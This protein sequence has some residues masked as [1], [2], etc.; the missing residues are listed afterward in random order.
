MA[1][2]GDCLGPYRLLR[3]IGSGGMG[4]V[5]A[6]IHERMEQEVA[7]KVLSAP[8]AEDPQLVGR[9]LQEGRALAQLQ[10]PGVVGVLHCDRLEDGTAFLAMELLSGLSL[11]E[12]MR[13]RLA[14]APLGESLAVAQQIAD[15]M[16][17]VHDRQ[18]VHRDLKPE[19]VFLCPDEAV[20]PGYRVKLLD[21]GIA[22]VP[23]ASGP[24]RGDTQVRTSAPTLIGTF[25]YM[26]P[27][28]CRNATDVDGR[29]DVYAL[30]V[31][32]FELLAGQPPFVSAEH[33]QIEVLSMHV[34]QQPP[35]L[36][37][38]APAVP[39]ALSAF[40]ASMLAKSPADR[41]TMARCRDMLGRGW[42]AEPDE[43]P[44][45]GLSPFSEAQAEL[46]FGRR[47]EVGEL[48]A[49]LERARAG[50]PRWI[51]IEGH[52]GVGKS[53]LV[54]AGILPRLKEQAHWRIA[55]VRAPDD[56][57]RALQGLLGS[58]P[59]AGSRLLLVVDQ[60]EEYLASGAAG[61]AQLD[62]QLFAALT[63]R[64]CPLS[65]L[66]TLRSDFV[67]RLEQMPLLTRG[68]DQAVRYHLRAMDEAAMAEVV[69]AM[70]RRAGLR[71]EEGL[72]ERMARDTRNE[73][74][75]LPLLGHTLRKLWS[76]RGTAP[77]THERY[78]QLGGVGGALARRRARIRRG[79][80]VVLGV[81]VVA[82]TVSAVRAYQEWRRAEALLQSV[83][84][85][86]D[87]IVDDDWEKSRIPHTLSSRRSQ[88]DQSL[89]N[90]AS[91]PESMRG[92]PQTRAKLIWTRHRLSDLAAAVDSLARADELLLETLGEIREGLERSPGDRE[93]M[94]LLALNHSKRGKVAMARGRLDEAR[95]D[96]ERSIDLL[97]RLPAGTDPVDDRRTLATSISELAELLARHDRFAEAA[98]HQDHAIA[99]FR[100][101][102]GP[103]NQCL[104]AA[105]LGTRGGVARQ[106]GDLAAAAGYLAEALS[107]AGPLTESK[108]WNQL[109]RSTLAR[110]HVEHA[111]LL[112]ARGQPAEA[113]DLYRAAEELARTVRTGEPENKAF[114][115]CLAESLLGHE[116]VA[117]ARGQQ[118]QAERLRA[119]RCALTEVF[120]RTDAEDIRFQ[121]LACR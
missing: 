32:L 94:L 46:F 72:P 60:L 44:I 120:V 9:F 69:E 4:Q 93:L 24:A 35:A 10:H 71:L 101:N 12:W 5:F 68:L 25:T 27:E 121:Q 78:E 102:P 81:A 82:I 77:L 34:H 38:A 89:K 66:T 74:S 55:C 58:Q 49:L 118:E 97:G 29:S 52:G 37:D 17:H 96:F 50:E 13:R 59:P 99:L 85:S 98:V 86:T 7:L 63:A 92:E 26:A 108:P 106:A 64:D 109:Y 110:I 48:L 54:Y 107:L 33:D 80:A 20:A 47:S 51:Q 83:I 8:A 22:K 41:P 36:R 103:Y 31:M 113:E 114:A 105:A 19:N 117:R 112:A 23:P 76:M 1:L 42:E 91:L 119:D 53:S 87:G 43:C 30:G 88:L 61:M 15:A 6:A 62:G 56:P 67:H 79:L 115:L 45:P 95:D 84:S 100:Q 21:F 3:L 18:I 65:L 57:L 28:Q 2:P 111:A 40:V 90:L 70:A 39:A 73:R 116:A 75:R 14:S 16:V 11:R 104:L